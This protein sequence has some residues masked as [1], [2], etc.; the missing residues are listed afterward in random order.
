M[1]KNLPLKSEAVSGSLESHA[2]AIAPPWRIREEFQDLVIGDIHGPAF[3][4]DEILPAQPPIRDR[5]LVGMLAPTE[6]RVNPAQVDD[7]GN[8]DDETKGEV[9]ASERVAAVGFFPSSLG[10]SCAVDG[11]V[12]EIEVRAEWGNYRKERKPREDLESLAG[13]HILKRD[14]KKDVIAACNVTRREQFASNWPKAMSTQSLLSRTILRFLF[15]VAPDDMARRGWSR[16]SSS[17]TSR[18]K[19]KTS[20]SSGFPGR[21]SVR[22]LAGNPSFLERHEDVNCEISPMTKTGSWR[23]SQCSTGTS[24][25]SPSGHGTRCTRSCS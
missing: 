18:H 1:S 24:S 9:S 19:R 15:A 23:S 25:S 22:G 7:P 16:S 2:F 17:T 4:V 10:L 3:G 13:F 14:A 11:S 20:I 5:Y 8:V 12:S 6:M 21:L